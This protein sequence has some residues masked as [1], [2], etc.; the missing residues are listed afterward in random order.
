MLVSSNGYAAS[1]SHLLL[2]SKQKTPFVDKKKKEKL[3]TPVLSDHHLKHP[4]LLGPRLAALLHD[5]SSQSNTDGRN[6]PPLPPWRISSSSSSSSSRPHYAD[7]ASQG[8]HPD[9]SLT[10]SRLCRHVGGVLEGY[11]DGNPRL[12]RPSYPRLLPLDGNGFRVPSLGSGR[13]TG[14]RGRGGRHDGIGHWVLSGTGGRGGAGRAS[15]R[16]DWSDYAGH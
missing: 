5:E 7:L 2:N 9:L 6:E 8:P 3:Q 10:G 4:I 12:R 14:S 15:G 16:D 13:R 11:G 1:K